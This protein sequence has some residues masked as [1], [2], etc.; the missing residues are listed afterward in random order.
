MIL[1]EPS[2]SD[3]I[4]LQPYLDSDFQSR[5]FDFGG[6]TIVRA[7]QYVDRVPIIRLVG[8]TAE[9]RARY[10]RLTSDRPSQQG[11]VFSRVPLTAT[12]WEVSF[13][14]SECR[15]GMVL[16]GARLNSNSNSMGTVTCTVM[17]SP[18]GSPSSVEHK[19]RFLA[20]QITS[21]VLV[22]SS[23]LTRTTVPV[24]HFPMSWP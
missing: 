17:D 6:D 24:P 3:T 10:I 19:V 5:W 18:C 7:D 20:R 9:R 13:F 4:K 2:T 22:F 16:I 1:S 8:T 21:R 11:W 15:V 14:F 12:N 23:T